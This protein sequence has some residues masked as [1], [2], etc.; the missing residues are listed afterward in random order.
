MAARA[1]GHAPARP[2]SP[3]FNGVDASGPDGGRGLAH[4][5]AESIGGGWG[6]GIAGRGA[7]QGKPRA[8][9]DQLGA[10]CGS[11]GRER[12]VTPG[13]GTLHVSQ[14]QGSLPHSSGRGDEPPQR[15]ANRTAATAAGAVAGRVSRGSP[16]GGHEY[17]TWLSVLGDEQLRAIRA[18]LQRAS[19][20]VSSP[21]DGL[22]LPSHQLLQFDSPTGAANSGNWMPESSSPMMLAGRELLP[23]PIHLAAT[24]FPAAQHRNQQGQQRQDLGHYPPALS[25]NVE[26]PSAPGAIPGARGNVW[27]G[28]WGP[29]PDGDALQNL[30]NCVAAQ[31]DIRAMLEA[32][33]RDGE[34]A[35]LSRSEELNRQMEAALALQKTLLSSVE[36]MTEE[37]LDLRSRLNDAEASCS[38]LEQERDWLQQRLNHIQLAGARLVVN[39]LEHVSM[40]TKVWALQRWYQ[41]TR[42][43]RRERNIF[44]H[45]KKIALSRLMAGRPYQ[46]A[47]LGW[48]EL[49]HVKC[50]VVYSFSASHRPRSRI[51]LVRTCCSEWRASVRAKKAMERKMRFRTTIHVFKSWVTWHMKRKVKRQAEA[52]NMRRAVGKLMN[53]IRKEIFQQWAQDTKKSRESHHEVSLVL[54]RSGWLKGHEMVQK[55]Y[56]TEWRRRYEHK[57]RNANIVKRATRKMNFQLMRTVWGRWSGYCMWEVAVRHPHSRVGMRDKGMHALLKLSAV[58]VCI[59]VSPSFV[60]HAT[61]KR[62]RTN[63]DTCLVCSVICRCPLAYTSTTCAYCICVRAHPCAPSLA[64][65]LQ[66]IDRSARNTHRCERPSSTAG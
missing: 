33:K 62:M 66:R 36:S 7:Q 53:Q 37:T 13:H 20:D 47:L 29:G 17:R 65:T 64:P 3:F 34:M 63:V 56:Y 35:L 59:F 18:T 46:R 23:S 19:E 38:Q 55:L 49:A 43:E 50:A 9:H 51:A 4:E 26:Q 14:L 48:R 40:R 54:Q 15:A 45:L 28:G 6:V 11:Q 31:E 61:R 2:T 41:T 1:R 30:A 52:V 16:R 57:K 58:L 39:G 44:A 24:V 21:T 42:S 32:G 60:L 12:S 10:A 27:R 5:D 22:I 25:T 8:V